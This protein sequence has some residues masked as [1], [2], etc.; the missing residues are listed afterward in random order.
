MERRE[1]G[2]LCHN[3][4]IYIYALCKYI[5]CSVTYLIFLMH[6]IS[7]IIHTT[8][9]IQHMAHGQNNCWTSTQCTWLQLMGEINRKLGKGKS[10]PHV[11][12]DLK[13]V[14]HQRP[15]LENKTAPELYMSAVLLFSL[16]LARGLFFA[17]SLVD[18]PR[19]LTQAPKSGSLNI[20]SWVVFSNINHVHP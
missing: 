1:P 17:F 8:Y 13:Y 7:L 4:S 2:I 9:Q 16:K 11:G 5:L 12:N 18:E 19:E 15:G 3:N 6:P 10:K 14:S 20:S